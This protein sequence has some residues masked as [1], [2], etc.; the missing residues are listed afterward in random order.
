MLAA[1][2]HSGGWNNPEFLF[3]VELGSPSAQNLA[4]A[5][6]G[7]DQKLKRQPR[8]C[9]SIFVVQPGEDRRHIAVWKRSVMLYS[10]ALLRKPAI[11]AVNRVFA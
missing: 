10:P 4:G 6:C 9:A 7:Q 5:C 2:F 1:G 8:R 11:D 3:Q